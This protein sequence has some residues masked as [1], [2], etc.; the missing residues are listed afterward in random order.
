MSE[1]DTLGR[2]KDTLLIL[3]ASYDS[4]AAAEADYEAVKAL[5]REVATSHDFDAAVIERDAE[6]KVR[7]VRKHEQ[8]TRHGAAK[9]LGWGLAIGAACVLFPPIGLGAV[10]VGG[11]AG[12]VVGAVTGHVKGGLDNIDLRLLGEALNRGQAGLI[13]VYATNL[14]AQVAASVKA[15][16]RH[17]SKEMDANTGEL[18]MQIK[19]AEGS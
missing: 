17:V 9:G 1:Y 2:E 7:V 13:A 19:A 6:G 10:A 18:A 4:L 12:A 15:E 3:A 5:Y 8:P 14:A 16:N 11:G